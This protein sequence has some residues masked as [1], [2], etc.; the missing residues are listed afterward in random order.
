VSELTVASF[1]IYWGA[2]ARSRTPFDVT[3]ACAALDADVLV[4]QEC[5]RR[6]GTAGHAADV[7]AAL[8]YEVVESPPMNRSI[9]FPRPTSLPMRRAHLAEGDWYFAVLSRLPVVSPTVTALPKLRLDRSRRFLVNID[10]DVDGARIPVAGTHLAHLE[11]GVMLHTRALRAALPPSDR[12]AVF[13]GDMNMW[14]WCIDLMAGR[15]WRRIVRGRTWPAR[16][17]HSQIDHILATPS[18]REVAS[19]V[20]TLSA[21]DHLPVRARVAF[22]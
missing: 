13:A 15:G 14:G 12:P 5:W 11:M 4:L 19:E 1:N 18:V 7:G 20:V 16:L 2:S 6:D 17:P 22:G 21:S 8:G 10:V 3:A 9:G